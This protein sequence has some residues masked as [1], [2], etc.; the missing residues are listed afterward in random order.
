MPPASAPDTGPDPNRL[1]STSGSNSQIWCWSL[2]AEFEALDPAEARS[3]SA[4]IGELLP[5][6]LAEAAESDLLTG[7]AGAV[8]GLLR[9]AE[10]TSD[11]RWLALAVE[12]GEQLVELALLEHG[13]A[14]W[15]SSLWPAGLG[16][17]AHGAT[18]IGWSLARL[19]Q[20][21]RSQ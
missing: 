12:A 8:V 6:A 15:A 4:R 5:G 17:F 19:S 11:T 10:Q 21:E 9:M 13:R 20:A 16:G 18:G 3:R 1:A 2:L 14:R 7:R